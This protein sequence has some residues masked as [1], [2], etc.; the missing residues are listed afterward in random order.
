MGLNSGIRHSAFGH[1]HL[2][3]WVIIYL[4]HREKLS[5]NRN[6]NYYPTNQS[7]PNREIL[8]RLVDHSFIHIELFSLPSM[9]DNLASFCRPTVITGC[10]RRSHSFCVCSSQHIHFQIKTETKARKIKKVGIQQS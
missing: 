4:L 10:T 5:G 6:K 1:D 8:V 2:L 9:Y 3:T 7:K